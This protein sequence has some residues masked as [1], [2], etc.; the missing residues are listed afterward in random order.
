MRARITPT[1]LRKTADWLEANPDLW[2]R[3]EK[4]TIVWFRKCADI[5]AKGGRIAN[6]RNVAGALKRITHP[7]ITWYQ[8]SNKQVKE[9]ALRVRD[10]LTKRKD[11]YGLLKINAETEEDKKKYTKIHERAMQRLMNFMKKY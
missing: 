6:F 7:E 3:G 8:K 11:K 1:I 5:L 10:K 9:Q 2:K 4:G